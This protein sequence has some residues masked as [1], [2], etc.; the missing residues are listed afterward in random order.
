VFNT[1]INHKD[2]DMV[3]PKSLL[4]EETSITK[5]NSQQ[6][7]YCNGF[8]QSVSTRRHGKQRCSNVQQLCLSGRR[9]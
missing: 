8:A 4:S 2:L 7:K 1:E 5:K 6:P 3:L 9:L